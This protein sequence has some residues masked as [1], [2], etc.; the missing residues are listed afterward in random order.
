MKQEIQVSCALM[1][2]SGD[3]V[4]SP[5]KTHV[6][7]KLNISESVHTSAEVAGDCQSK[8][9]YETARDKRVAELREMFKP[10]QDAAIAL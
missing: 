6:P 4:G 9:S 8:G 3:S 7:H 1:D 2:Y 10:V 5:I